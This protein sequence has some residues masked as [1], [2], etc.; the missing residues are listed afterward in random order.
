MNLYYRLKELEAKHEN[1]ITEVEQQELN[2]LAREYELLH[3]TLETMSYHA[4]SKYL[5]LWSPF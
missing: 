3:E 5:E 4:Q 2:D 1:D